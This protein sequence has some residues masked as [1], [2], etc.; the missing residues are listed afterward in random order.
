MIRSQNVFLLNPVALLLAASSIG[1][2]LKMM[3]SSK[4]VIFVAK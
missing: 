3:L 4:L 1:F 2:F